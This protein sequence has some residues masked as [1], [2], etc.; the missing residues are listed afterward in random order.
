MWL[1]VLRNEWPTLLMMATIFSHILIIK[2]IDNGRVTR[3]CP[4][5]RGSSYYS[6][7]NIIMAYLSHRIP[8]VS[9]T[10]SVLSG[11][12][13]VVRWLW[14]KQILCHFHSLIPWII[15]EQDINNDFIGRAQSLIAT[16][17]PKHAALNGLALIQR[18]DHHRPHTENMDMF[19]FVRDARTRLQC[20]HTKHSLGAGSWPH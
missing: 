1:N 3:C 12:R 8:S 10:Q 4:K 19:R 17:H 16:G 18:I 9:A 20:P 13:S 7:L 14:P 11:G 2:T 15:L 5:L 6:R